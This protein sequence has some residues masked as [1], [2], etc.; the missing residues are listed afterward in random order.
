VTVV[1]GAVTGVVGVVIVVVGVVGGVTGWGETTKLTDELVALPNG[2]V[3]V[4][5]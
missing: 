3:T 2:L 1:G 5:A 4:H